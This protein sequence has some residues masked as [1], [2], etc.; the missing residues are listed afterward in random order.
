M[1]AVV[2]ISAAKTIARS[3]ARRRRFSFAPDRSSPRSRSSLSRSSR[4]SCPIP[5]IV[6]GR[7]HDRVDPAARHLAQPRQRQAGAARGEGGRSSSVRDDILAIIDDGSDVR[8]MLDLERW[9]ASVPAD[10]SEGQAL[11]AASS[12]FDRQARR[13]VGAAARGDTV[14]DEPD[15]VSRLERHRRPGRAT[16]PGRCHPQAARRAVSRQ[17]ERRRGRAEGGSE[18][19]GGTRDADRE[20]VCDQCLSRQVRGRSSVPARPSRGE[21]DRDRPQSRDDRDHRARDQRAAGGPS[22]P[23]RRNG[24]AACRRASRA[25]RRDAGVGARQRDPRPAGGTRP[26][27]RPVVGKPRT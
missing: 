23:R 6:G 18:D 15:G 8:A 12:A 27:V 25:A 11:P 19:A 14:A 17:G 26:A 5:S 24:G 22:R 2:R 21:P 13:G 20:R 16:A 4:A 10:L 3:S 9:L 7:A 1:V